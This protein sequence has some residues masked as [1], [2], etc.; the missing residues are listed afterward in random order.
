MCS[1]ASVVDKTH[2]H[3]YFESREPGEVPHWVKKD[4]ISTLIDLHE[5]M[6]CGSGIL[7]DVTLN[8]SLGIFIAGAS[9][10]R[11]TKCCQRETG[12]V[13]ANPPRAACT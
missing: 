3:K 9:L 5:K 6:A 10:E 12:P 11:C 1:N 4:S 13:R 2:E 8:P 7:A